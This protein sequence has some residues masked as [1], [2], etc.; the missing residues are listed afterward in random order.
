MRKNISENVSQS[1]EIVV[2]LP[3]SYN[4]FGNKPSKNEI[5]KHKTLY[6]EPAP[7]IVRTEPV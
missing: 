7:G 1:S 3:Q 6:E 4:N 5:K 2:L